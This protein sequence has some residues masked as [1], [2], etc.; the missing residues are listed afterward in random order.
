MVSL[1]CASSCAPSN[2]CF[3][4]MT[5]YKRHINTVF[6]HCVSSCASSNC[7]LLKTILY[8]HY[9]NTSFLHRVIYCHSFRSIVDASFLNLLRAMT[10]FRN[11][12]FSLQSVIS[13]YMCQ[14][15]YLTNL[16]LFFLSYTFS[17]L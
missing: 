7:Y 1:H 3:V 14:L 9:K 12:Q 10:Y 13:S 2:Y 8:K 17:M 16:L 11:V 4:K 5:S 6:P 15:L